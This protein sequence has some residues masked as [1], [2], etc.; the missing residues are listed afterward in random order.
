M[1]DH[2]KAREIAAPFATFTP[3]ACFTL[4][5]ESAIELA[6]AYRDAMSTLDGMAQVAEETGDC[7]CC[8]FVGGKHDG[9]CQ[10][11]ARHRGADESEPE[12]GA[13]PVLK[14]YCEEDARVLVEVLSDEIRTENGKR[15]RYITVRC[16][17][18]LE[19]GSGIVR[20]RPGERWEA[21]GLL[22]GESDFLNAY[23][24]WYL[25]EPRGDEALPATAAGQ[26][27]RVLN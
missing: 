8:A 12:V 24:P 13:A 20:A 17:R 2:K 23:V 11:H 22:Q 14:V 6:S 26:S 16:V 9:T 7:P 4:K 27:S 18:M 10:L 19:R 21:V 3:P 25:E 1:A 15:F 5:R